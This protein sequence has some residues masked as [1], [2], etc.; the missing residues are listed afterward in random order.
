MHT[1]DAPTAAEDIDIGTRD[2]TQGL[3]AD[4]PEDAFSWD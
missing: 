3:D 2:G 4:S 1:E